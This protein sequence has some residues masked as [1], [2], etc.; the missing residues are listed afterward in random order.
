[1]VGTPIPGPVALEMVVG[2]ED[3]LEDVPRREASY[4]RRS[5]TWSALS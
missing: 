1:M 3:H 5:M 4:M 2:G